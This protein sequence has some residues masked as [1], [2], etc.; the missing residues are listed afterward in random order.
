MAPGM[1]SIKTFPARGV[2]V[3][4][5]QNNNVRL[6]GTYEN[7]F[8]FKEGFISPE[9][10]EAIGGATRDSFRI[11]ANKHGIRMIDKVVKRHGEPK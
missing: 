6:L 3:K 11:F 7:P 5:G 1:R 2:R 8:A 9:Q 4:T 10:P